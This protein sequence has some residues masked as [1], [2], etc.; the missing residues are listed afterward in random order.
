[1]NIRGEVSKHDAGDNRKVCPVTWTGFDGLDLVLVDRKGN[2]S[3][4]H[5]YSRL[6][7][8]GELLRH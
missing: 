6:T 7:T 4:N 5:G 3:H 8:G 2:G 1:M